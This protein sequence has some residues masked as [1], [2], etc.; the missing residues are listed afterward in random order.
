MEANGAQ[1]NT[2]DG[3]Q[4]DFALL[5]ALTLTEPLQNPN[6]TMVVSTSAPMMQT[7]TR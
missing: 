4:D 2:G 1:R 5:T 6:K 7:K 3:R